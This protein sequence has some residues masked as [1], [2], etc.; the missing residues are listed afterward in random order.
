[1]SEKKCF[2]VF[3]APSP[4]EMGC[5]L[6]WAKD[7]QQARSFGVSLLGFVE[8]IQ[9]RARREPRLDPH[10]PEGRYFAIRNADLPAK[11][12]PFFAEENRGGNQ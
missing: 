9:V 1:M 2:V 12:E 11:V 5:V 4:W 7:A 8:Y 10:C 3:E 6:V